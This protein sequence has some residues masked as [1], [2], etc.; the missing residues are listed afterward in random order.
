MT[1]CLLTVLEEDFL[2]SPGIGS[3]LA[4]IVKVRLEKLYLDYELIHRDL[5]SALETS[6]NRDEDFRTHVAMYTMHTNH[7][8]A[9][10]INLD[11]IIHIQS[12][13]SKKNTTPTPAQPM[14]WNPH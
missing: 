3:R 14:C 9:H 6:M 8:E 1:A 4:I 2:E 11:K 7:V 13:R 12:L 10:C 5:K